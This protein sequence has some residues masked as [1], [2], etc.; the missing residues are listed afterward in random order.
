MIKQENFSKIDA[1]SMPGQMLKAAREA[2]GITTEE[3]SNYLHLTVTTI[4]SIEA[5]QYQKMPAPVYVKGYLRRYAQFVNLSPDDVLKAFEQNVEV[6]SKLLE[7]IPSYARK[8]PI[9]SSHIGIR[10]LTYGILLLFLILVGLWW[11]GHEGN[12]EPIQLDAE[13]KETHQ[14]PAVHTPQTYSPEKQESSLGPIILNPELM[15][16]PNKEKPI[17]TPPTRK[18]SDTLDLY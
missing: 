9:T 12:S 6:K 4:L 11:K 13:K 8:K 5:D 10:I 2:Q 15:A 14:Q 7:E 18:S 16:K 17:K 3:V 1:A